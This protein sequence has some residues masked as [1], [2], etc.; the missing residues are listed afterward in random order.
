MQA[1]LLP[2]F[3]DEAVETQIREVNLPKGLMSG[4]KKK[5]KK[6]HKTK[7]KKKK[8]KLRAKFLSGRT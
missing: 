7:S 8:K 2:Q 6:K 4:N 3:P 1:F 5:K